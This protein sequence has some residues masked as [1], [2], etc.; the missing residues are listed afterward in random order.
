M[1]YWCINI[2]LLT[3]KFPF[4]KDKNSKRIPESSYVLNEKCISHSGRDFISK[5]LSSNIT[6]RLTIVSALQHK[7]IKNSSQHNNKCMSTITIDGS[8]YSSMYKHHQSKL[9]NKYSI[10]QKQTK[11]YLFISDQKKLNKKITK[12]NRKISK[13][14]S[15]NDDDKSRRKSRRNS[16]K[17]LSFPF[18][19]YDKS[20]R[21]S[22]KYLSSNIK[23]KRSSINISKS[24]TK[25]L[26]YNDYCD[27]E[28]DS[29][30]SNSLIYNTNITESDTDISNTSSA[31]ISDDNNY[32]HIN[33]KNKL[34][35]KSSSSSMGKNKQK[36]KI[37][38]SKTYSN[39]HS[40][41]LKKKRRGKHHSDS[42]RMDNRYDIKKRNR[43]N[44]Q[45]TYSEYRANNNVNKI[46]VESMCFLYIYCF[47]CFPN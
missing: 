47:S 28:T 44:S 32:I 31:D 29:N 14:Q 41:K 42:L 6:N 4:F 24:H 7:W 26:T 35:N 9:Q 12:L 1:E 11:E 8:I 25:Y 2:L 23:G 30:N 33:V 13:Y 46:D 3:A 45:H 17:Y 39:N 22:S 15:Y 16:S 5:L 20:R 21:K 34:S 40:K 43:S 37:K 27:A 36:Q 18:N 10:V 38:K 19:I